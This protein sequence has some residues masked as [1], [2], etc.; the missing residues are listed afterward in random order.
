M[1]KLNRSIPKTKTFLVLTLGGAVSE[2][3]DAI[4]IIN[5]RFPGPCRVNVDPTPE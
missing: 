4:G 3:R 5:R 1:D 2:N